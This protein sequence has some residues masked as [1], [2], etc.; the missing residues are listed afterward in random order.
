MGRIGR[1]LI[2]AICIYPIAVSLG[3]FLIEQFSSN[4]H[5]R[6][7]EAIMT[8]MFAIGPFSAIIAFIVGFIRGKKSEQ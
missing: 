3:Y 6:A 2:Y 1:G 7:L 5:D 4:R 8:S